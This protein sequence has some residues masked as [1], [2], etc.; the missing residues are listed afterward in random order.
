MYTNFYATLVTYCKHKHWVRNNYTLTGDI[1]GI[2]TALSN[3]TLRG[4]SDGTV[5]DECGTA[6]WCVIRDKSI[7]RGVTLIP[8]S[9]DKMDS[10]RSELGGLYC[11]LRITEIIMLEHIPHEI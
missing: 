5:G 4:V 3:G 6:G 1:S 11:M 10:T 8:H 9:R 7:I 2:H